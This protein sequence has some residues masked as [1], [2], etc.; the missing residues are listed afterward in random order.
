M[1]IGGKLVNIKK[2][3]KR[4][5]Q[6]VETK[7]KIYESAE[8]LFRK[9]G[10][11][12]VSVDSI[13]ERAGVSKGS[14]YVHF[15]SKDALILTLMGDYVGKVDLEYR[16]YLESLPAGTKAADILFSFAE[17]IVD[18]IT[19]TIGY[20]VIKIIYGFQITQTVNTDTILGYN[21]DL[22]KIFQN[23][24]SQGIQ[25]K[26][27]KPEVNINI[28]AQHFVMA[29]RGLTYEWC[30]RSPDFDLKDYVRQ[31]FEILLNGIRN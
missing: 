9:Y 5:A 30:I 8:Q 14:F 20:D 18:V 7:N 31:H 11:D 19:D 28:I 1:S 3:G 10:F 6:A 29:I 25:Q 22:Y 24:I 16:T 27:F 26:E 21:R 2:M 15:K 17:K 12:Q 4:K 23:I 13:V